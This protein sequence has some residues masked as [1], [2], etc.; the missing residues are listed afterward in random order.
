MAG[1]K[2]VGSD[3]FFLTRTAALDLRNIHARSLREWGKEIA[4]AYLADLYSVIQK[5]VAN[6]ELGRLRHHRS[7]PFLMVP[8]RKHFLI[9]DCIPE[10]IAILTVQHQVR[11][12]ETLIGTLTP[13]FYAEVERLKKI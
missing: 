5:V 11:D 3:S 7:A 10:G 12:I 9:Y 8:A 6:P 1:S 4:D 2:Q 13:A